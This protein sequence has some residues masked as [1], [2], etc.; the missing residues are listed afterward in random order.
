M[1]CRS[2]YRPR[3]RALS[4]TGSQRGYVEIARYTP[5]G[6]FH[7]SRAACVAWQTLPTASDRT[8]AG[9]P[10][11]GEV[12][13]DQNSD[14]SGMRHHTFAASPAQIPQAAHRDGRGIQQRPVIP[15]LEHERQGQRG[16][17]TSVGGLKREAGLK[18]WR[19]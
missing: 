8:N 14:V 10:N 2:C 13:V 12:N 17:G 4:Q 6:P 19:R 16:A 18:V 5:G 3:G 11:D 15:E 1:P 7:P 9:S